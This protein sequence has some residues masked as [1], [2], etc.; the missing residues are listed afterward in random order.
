[1][2][3]PQ[4]KFASTFFISQLLLNGPRMNSSDREYNGMMN[5]VAS[6]LA[7]HI[8]A[9]TARISSGAVETREGFFQRY[10]GLHPDGISI[11][12]VIV[13]DDYN[14][15]VNPV[16]TRDMTVRL[17]SFQKPVEELEKELT[18]VVAEKYRIRMKGLVDSLP[19]GAP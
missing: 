16:K 5:A 1:M 8:R 2:N 4:P 19:K 7:G 13:K 12:Y 10:A 6:K 15:P 18:A 17:Q 9:S 11:S 14:H 3:K